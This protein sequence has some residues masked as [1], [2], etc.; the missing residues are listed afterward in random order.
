[1]D[2]ATILVVDDTPD[3]IDILVGILG[4]DYKVKIAINGQKALALAAK[5]APDLILLD[6]MMPDMN[7]YEVC[8]RLKQD[9]LTRHIPVIFVTALAETADE[10][11]GFEIGGVDYI[12]KPVSASVVKARVKTH[13]TLQNQKRL[14]KE[15]V[16]K[17][18]KDLEE[19]RFEIIRRLGRAAEYKDNETGLHVV[20]VSHYAK[21][22]AKQMG[23]SEQYCEIIYYAAAMHDVGKIGTPDAVL[24]KPGKLDDQEW[25]TMQQHAAIGAEIIGRHNDPL[26]Q[27]SYNIALTHHEKWNG[28][29]YPNGMQGEEIPL[30]GRI[31]A[32]ADV[33]DALTS[34]RPYKKAWKIDD[35]IGLIIS[36][37]GRHFDPQLVEHFK[38]TIN[39][40]IE[41]HDTYVE[42]E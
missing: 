19:T 17:Q 22:L 20:R 42:E 7:G 14:L 30:E 2:K 9:P 32:I 26:L 40:I 25:E 34:K 31:V 35:A 41:I 15:E 10:T 23:L 29:G 18:T 3:N 4:S 39:Q 27:M 1:M 37:A 12:T 6:V 5:T 16:R 38:Q 28:S 13:I 33:F 8:Q 21:I 24:R 11:Q 36:E